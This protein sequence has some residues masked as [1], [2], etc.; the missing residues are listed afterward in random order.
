MRRAGW[1]CCGAQNFC[2]AL[3]RT[4]EILTAATRS[5]R[6]IRHRRR[7]I[8]SLTP[9][10]WCG[11][12]RAAAHGCRPAERFVEAGGPVCPVP[13][14]Q[15][16]C[17]A[18]PM[19]PAAYGAPQIETERFLAGGSPCIPRQF[20]YERNYLSWQRRKQNRKPSIPPRTPMSWACGARWWSSPSPLPWTRTICPTL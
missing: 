18:G 11:V 15:R 8:H 14:A 16:F 6:F 7:S 19:C 3:R 1:S 20:E 17:M 9:P 5:F 4:L 2:A 12:Y 13:A 10:R